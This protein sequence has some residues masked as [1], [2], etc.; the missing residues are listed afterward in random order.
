MCQYACVCVCV[1]VCESVCA[2][3]CEREANPDHDSKG[4]LTI[5]TR[6]SEMNKATK[7]LY[8]G[9][10]CCHPVAPLGFWLLGRITKTYPDKGGFVRS[11][12]LKIKN[13]PVG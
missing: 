9:R 6:E 7:K 3:E 4:I 13:W 12:Q 10:H 5:T 1:C 2:T 8:C 11:V